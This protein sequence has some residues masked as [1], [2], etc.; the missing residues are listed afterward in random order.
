MNSGYEN[1]EGS[2]LPAIPED[3]KSF[4]LE[5]TGAQ[6]TSCYVTS[7]ESV[8]VTS[9]GLITPKIT[10]WY[11][12][13][14]MGT[15]VKPEDMTGW[16][17][18]HDITTGVS[19]VHVTTDK[20]E[21][22]VEAE[23]IDYAY[24]YADSVIDRFVAE[25]ITDTMTVREIAEAAGKFV[26]ENYEYN[27]KYSSCTS[28]IIFGGGDCWASTDTV[29]RICRKAGLKAWGRNGNKDS[30]SGS[31]HENALVE[32]DG[33]WYEVEAGYYEPKPRYYS[34]TERHSLFCIDA[35]AGTVNGGWL[36]AQHDG[37]DETRTELV[38][39]AELDGRKI[40]GVSDS[41]AWRSSEHVNWKNIVLEDGLEV[42]AQ[43][44]FYGCSKLESITIP[45]SVNRIDKI[46]FSNC[47]K[48]S[49]IRI[50]PASEYFTEDG[51]VIY[52]KD[53]KSLVCAPMTGQA[54]IPDTVEEIRDYA[55]Y[56]NKNV[57]ELTIPASVKTI[58]VGAFGDTGINV[59]MF[60][61]DMP[62][63]GEYAFH[64]QDLIVFYPEGNETWDTSNNYSASSVKWIPYKAGSVKLSECQVSLDKDLYMYQN[65][66]VIP[67]ITVTY[68]GSQLTE[69][70]DYLV[71]F[72]KN[73]RVGNAVA[74]IYGTGSY[75]GAVS[76]PFKITPSYYFSDPADS[77]I[78]GLTKRF[79]VFAENYQWSDQTF[80][81]ESSDPSIATVEVDKSG[82]GY[83]YFWVTAVEPGTVRLIA[84]DNYGM[85]IEHVLTVEPAGEYHAGKAATCTEA[86]W[87]EYWTKD[88]KYYRDE[89]CRAE[90]SWDSFVI[91][92]AGHDWKNA[93]Y[94]KTVNG[95]AYLTCPACGQKLTAKVP[96]GF[97]VY[98]NSD[99]GNSYVTGLPAKMKVGTVLGCWP[100]NFKYTAEADE[101]VNEMVV[102]V[103]PQAADVAEAWY[104]GVYDIAWKEPGRHKVVVYP[105]Y[106]PSCRKEFTIT[107]VKSL[108][109]ADVEVDGSTGL[110][111]GKPVAVS[112]A[113]DGGIGALSYRFTLIDSKG[114]EMV[115]SDWSTVDSVIWT[116][117]RSGSFTVRADV[118]DDGDDGRTV[119][120]LSEKFTVAK[121]PAP[122]GAPGGQFSVPYS[123]E[124]VTNDIL[125]DFENWEFDPEFVGRPLAIGETVE[126]VAVYTGADAENYESTAVTVQITRSSCAHAQTEVVEKNI[127]EPTCVNEGGYDS[128]T[129]CKD[130]GEELHTRHVTLEPAGHSWND[131]V[132]TVEPTVETEGLMTFTCTA[133][134]AEK[135]EVIPVL[136]DPL[137]QMGE[138]GT[139]LGRGA[140]A[141]AAE[142][143]ILG[144][145]GDDD[146][147]GSVFGKLQLKSPKQT[148][149]SVTISWK[150]LSGASTYVVYGNKCG[151]TN[152][153]RRL[154]A[155]GKNTL[156]V[157][158]VRSNKGAKVKVKKGAY[159]KFIV[160]A[161]DADGNVVSASKVI[162]AV[163]K[164]GKYC[165]H[166]SVTIQKKSGSKWK[167]VKSV[168]VKAGKRVTIRGVG[169]K[170]SGKLK[171]RTHVGTRYES[172]K[173]AVATVSK[174]G[175]L[176]GRKKG[177]CYV[178]AYTQNGVMKKFKIVVK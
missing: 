66:P 172:A 39:P 38:V 147:A 85:S 52:S 13:G 153:M 107:V 130:C 168:T 61:G 4:Q 174:K 43:S 54:Q 162:H 137:E 143:A 116:A 100:D 125:A 67:G 59:L 176:K 108:E 120:A 132:V 170:E 84:K 71:E 154:K 145:T 122:A 68:Q 141:E 117:D 166:K 160:V 21:F 87:K 139:A 17:V 152:R 92:A 70:Q 136:P 40:T 48:L 41:F 9:D 165:N 159:Y 151:S 90:A 163:T 56:Y 83:L 82:L 76:R 62:A 46:A 32:G 22:D 173:P 114:A 167:T 60:E 88:G 158:Y 55:F 102:E 178:Y 58:G 42:I 3:K 97:T 91:P 73:D 11:W 133:C 65:E 118:K 156:T 51:G 27:A 131:G 175:V 1:A 15:S 45:A 106:N 81:V 171:Y 18:T 123:Q 111:Y 78:A 75:T 23:V 24:V 142:E 72:L 115:L 14:G 103:D 146:P 2:T 140:S 98:W 149:A 7:G 155:T 29:V 129:I 49:D 36:L 44:G 79:Y 35:K 101:S 109:G 20:G 19:T 127:V 16:T 86:G 31:G 104:S 34:V 126:G 12:N 119:S 8:T 25:N 80:T 47:P 96:T 33:V 113:A 28:M 63:I 169:V 77:L 6:I 148:K 128:V 10:T 164:G 37:I 121:A 89:L 135:T 161:L 99:G 93:E 26:A 110:M 5:V 53:K 150:S 134:G 144:M 124:T 94:E 50:D 95:L 177:S 157:K 105:K 138:D 74:V 112:A 64:G 30:G 57:K 69:G